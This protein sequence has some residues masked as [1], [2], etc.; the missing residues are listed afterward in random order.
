M[1]GKRLKNHLLVIAAVIILSLISVLT[2]GV[3]GLLAT[4][5]LA[6]VIGYSVTRFHYYFVTLICACT[7]AVTALFTRNLAEA[8]S[9]MLPTI[10]CG[11]SLGIAYNLKISEGK[12]ISLLSCIY[13]LYFVLTI[14]LSGTNDNG[15]NIIEEAVVTSSDMYQE[16][17]AKMYEGYISAAEISQLISS[18]ITIITKFMPAFIIIACISIAILYFNVFKKVLQITKCDTVFY[19]PFPAWHADKSFS[20]MFIIISILC[21]LS[22]A[23]DYLGDVL[24]NAIVV[25]C[26]IFY[27]FGLA[28]VNYLFI[29]FI[30]KVALRRLIIISIAL[31]SLFTMGVPFIGL[32]ALG[33]LDGFVDFR[34]RSAKNNLPE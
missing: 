22:P 1:L 25:S 13:T 23:D 32:V 29:K 15:Q 18:L 9:Y 30:K 20:V 33:V 14:S 26:F 8:F 19:K 2:L 4:A 24:A 27:M 16:M 31:L 17:I 28:Y 34:N 11:L 7:V 5:I 10:L 21:F 12:I 6:S 3:S